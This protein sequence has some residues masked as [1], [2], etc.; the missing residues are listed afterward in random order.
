MNACALLDTF[1]VELY[2]YDELAA[3]DRDRVAAHRSSMRRRRTTGRGSCGDSIDQ[4][5]RVGRRTPSRARSLASRRW[6]P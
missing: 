2:F 6:R 1:D 3:A 5:E 4:P